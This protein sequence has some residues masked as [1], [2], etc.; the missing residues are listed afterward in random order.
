MTRKPTKSQSRPPPSEEDEGGES[1][2]DEGED[3]ESPRKSSGMSFL[4]VS[5]PFT[6]HNLCIAKKSGNP[7]EAK[8]KTAIESKKLASK[9]EFRQFKTKTAD[10]SEI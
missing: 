10:S 3:A 7:V 6:D 8:A 2:G 1:D 4:P 9:G 5:K